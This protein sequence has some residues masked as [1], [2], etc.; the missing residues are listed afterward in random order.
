MTS[1]I[2]NIKHP[3]FGQYIQTVFDTPEEAN[4]KKTASEGKYGW[5]M[6]NDIATDYLVSLSKNKTV[7][8]L[9]CAWGESISLPCLKNEA[10][11]VFAFDIEKEHLSA[12]SEKAILFGYGDR[13]K[14]QFIEDDWWFRPF[15]G[16]GSPRIILNVPENESCPKEN[17]VDLMFAR[18]VIQFGNLHSI[19]KVF[20][21]ASAILK[22]DGQF[23]AI[24]FSPYTHYL[25]D[26][27]QGETLMKI[28]DWNAQ[29]AKGEIEK[30]G[31]YLQKQDGLAKLSL[32]DLWSKKIGDSND[33]FVLFDDDVLSGLLSLWGKSRAERN[34][35]INLILD[36]TTLFSPDNI[37]MKNKLEENQDFL[38]KENHLFVLRKIV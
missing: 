27:D 9:G 12:V 4:C 23:A 33:P 21:L 22:P 19:L 29:F 11:A 2:E 14:T 25:Y 10:S 20:D 31:S 3:L 37:V 38:E 7:V 17:S 18:H 16:E 35:P 32:F 34:L 28:V 15:S 30:P 26:Y 6:P 13:L 24:N 1:R 8:D 5:E 36:K